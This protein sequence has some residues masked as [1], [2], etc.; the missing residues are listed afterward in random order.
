M[1]KALIEEKSVSQSE[2]SQNR[3][4]S[5]YEHASYFLNN[6]E[7]FELFE[8]LLDHLYKKPESALTPERQ[9]AK[10]IGVSDM[11]V[12]KWKNKVTHPNQEHAAKIL[13][14]ITKRDPNR[15][16]SRIA[17]LSNKLMEEVFNTYVQLLDKEAFDRNR[18]YRCVR[19][20][21]GDLTREYVFDLAILLL[22]D[23]EL[24][25][26][27]SFLKYHGFTYNPEWR[28]KYMQSY[29]KGLQDSIDKLKKLVNKSQA[30][31]DRY[32]NQK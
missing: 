14:E 5:C 4:E 7:R 6:A 25:E 13:S 23:Q 8:I 32:V 27:P 15:I 12:S 30:K 31:Y 28:R 10:I 29:L 22:F 9:V 21:S 11:T 1:E 18:N 3:I 2:F 17:A 20:Y 24:A 19:T 26:M 16:N